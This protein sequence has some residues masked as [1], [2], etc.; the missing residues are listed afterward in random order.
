MSGTPEVAG[1]SARPAGGSALV[2]LHLHSTASDGAHTPAE[3]A[4]AAAQAGLAAIALTDH[5]TLA[6]VEAARAAG[7]RLGL[8]VIAGVELSAYEAADR[9]THVLGLHVDRSEELEGHLRA[10]RDTRRTRAE[11]IV[12][13]LNALGVPLTLEAVLAQAG[14]GAIGRPHVARAL[15]AGGWVADH[16]EAFDRYLG[17]GRAA[18]VPKHRLTLAD[19]IRLVHEAGGIA[20]LAH[21]GPQCTR[22]R[23]EQLVRLGLDG[24]EVLHPSHGTEDVR[25]LR[26]LVEH[27][28]LVPS[29]GSDW[30]GAPE[31][32]RALGSMHVP[33]EWLERQ[34]VR[35]AMLAAHARV[36]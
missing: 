35:V 9:E 20:V 4:S 15:V 28:R 16:R 32:P 31:G 13:R 19:A 17:A 26:A 21:P 27:F 18:F 14:E 1:P 36:A 25:R 5:D 24:L 30:H 23:V 7:A 8:R 3:V 12:T 33:G 2:D 10:F 22:D 6:G 11:Q 29:G 34:Q